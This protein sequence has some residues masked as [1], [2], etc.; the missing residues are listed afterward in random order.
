MDRG[1]IVVLDTPAA[2]KASVGADRVALGTAD[3]TAA[4]AAL[5]D[6]FCIEAAVAGGAVTFHVASGEAFVPRLFAEL[7]VGIT[8]VAVSRP[9]LDDVFM[10]YTGSTIRDAETASAADRNREI[11]R[12]LVKA[13][14]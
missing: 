2:L 5:R 4:L 14:R 11:A 8:S 1:E 6:R 3:D 12:A 7:G 9:T 10:R 13:G